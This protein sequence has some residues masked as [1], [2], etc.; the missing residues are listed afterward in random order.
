MK[1]LT[2]IAATGNELAIKAVANELQDVNEQKEAIERELHKFSQPVIQ[3]IPTFNEFKKQAQVVKAL[4]SPKRLQEK[5][6]IV[7]MFVK[8]ISFDP[9]E[10]S[11][12]VEYYK[13]PFS[14]LMEEST[15]KQNPH[16]NA[17]EAPFGTSIEMVA[18]TGFEPVTFG[19]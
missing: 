1:S 19:L 3:K 11:A 15:K 5:R 4:L 14:I 13:N 7:W 2:T 6:K 8:A 10:K 17:K 16:Y 12:I 9:I 18:G